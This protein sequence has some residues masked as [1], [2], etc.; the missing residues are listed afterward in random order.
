MRISRLKLGVAA[1]ASLWLAAG[2][3]ALAASAATM[4]AGSRTVAPAHHVS[5]FGLGFARAPR[6]IA[7][8]RATAAPASSVTEWVSKSA[9]GN[10]SSC[11]SPGFNTISAALANAPAGARVKVCKG[12]YT[13]Q[14]AITKSVTLRSVGAV[15]I[16]LPAS[17]AD[18]LTACD[19][20]GGAQPNQD[21][22]DICGAIRVSMSGFKIKG[23]WPSNV[24]NDSLYGVA[25]L[26]GANLTLTRSTVTRVG[27]NPRSDGCQGGVGI[28]VGLATSGTTA[29]PGRA[30]LRRVI[31]RA[32]QKNGITVDGRGSSARMAGVKVIGAGATQAIAQNGIQVSDGASAAI[33]GSTVAGD[34]CSD[35]AADCGPNGFTQTQSCGILLFD[36]GA[37]RVSRSKVTASDIGVYNIE[38]YTWTYYQPPASFTPVLEHFSGLH[39]ANRYENAY[40]DEGASALASSQLSG[41]EVGIESAQWNGQTTPPVSRATG[42]LIKHASQDAVLVASDSAVGDQSVSMRIAGSRF[43][44]SNAHGIENQ[45]TSVLSAVRDWWGRPTGPSV[46]SFG[47]GASVSSDVSFFPWAL[48]LGLHR[49]QACRTTS[50]SI[51]TTRTRVVLC[52]KPGSANVSLTNGGAGRVL[53]IG[54]QGN[55]KLSGSGAG[56]ETWI[57]T[58]TGGANVV[59]G[60]GGTGYIQ[61]RGNP[62]DIL[63]NVADYTVAAN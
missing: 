44:T 12:T 13:E 24:C 35:T 31:V 23:N 55:D 37:V 38:D 58:G 61:E 15:T 27:G 18:N 46:W 53:L 25:V 32:Y 3:G 1:A 41:G 63:K 50:G 20:D 39:L 17:P 45:S 42:V 30:T 59:N 60:N 57:I 5:P 28:E 19:A 49:F 54:N 16:V 6:H 52:A 21:I 22:V 43:G 2:S 36:A 48:N 47:T 10:D 8:R 33:T 56:G 9:Q 26:G 40:F 4:H 51:T 62:A 11:A 14:L 34:E 29:D 7:K